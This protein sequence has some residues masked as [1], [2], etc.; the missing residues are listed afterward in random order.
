MPEDVL[1]S[2]VSYSAARS[3][4]QGWL[5]ENPE[6][7]LSDLPMD[8]LQ[9]NP[10]DVI[11]PATMSQSPSAPGYSQNKPTAE[12]KNT[13]PGIGQVRDVMTGQNPQALQEA[14]NS[15]N[16]YAQQG[17]N[18]LGADVTMSA[19]Q[20]A[21]G[22]LRIH[23][24]LNT[25][26]D[27]R[28]TASRPVSSGAPV[29]SLWD[30]ASIWDAV[31]KGVNK[32]LDEEQEGD[33]GVTTWLKA[34]GYAVYENSAAVGIGREIGR[35]AEDIASDTE[36]GGWFGALTSTAANLGGFAYD[37]AHSAT[38]GSVEA[39]GKLL[40]QAAESMTRPYDL[41]EKEILAS[42]MEYRAIQQR[43][44]ARNE[45]EA[46]AIDKTAT[47]GVR[48]VWQIPAVQQQEDKTAEASADHDPWAGPSQ[49]GFISPDEREARRV[50]QQ[51]ERQLRNRQSQASRQ[52]AS[53]QQNQSA[54]REAE[55][56]A[57]QQGMQSLAS[58]MAVAA[59][60]M[61]AY[62]RAMEQQR[63][64]QNQNMQRVVDGINQQYEDRANSQAQSNSANT[65]YPTTDPIAQ[66]YGQQA[67]TEQ[68]NPSSDPWGDNSNQYGQQSGKG[69]GAGSTESQD[70]TAR[71][72]SGETGNNQCHWWSLGTDLARQGTLDAF[73]W[74]F[75]EGCDYTDKMASAVQET[76]S[77][78]A[79]Y[80]L[81]VCGMDFIIVN[82]KSGRSWQ[83]YVQRAREMGARRIEVGE[84]SRG[85]L[86][87]CSI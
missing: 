11:D 70:V 25:D 86:I 48:D 19:S 3:Q 28:V 49:S 26:I 53:R 22:A 50:R 40:G 63:Q 67:S 87:S 17:V 56:E 84:G 68:K 76:F 75:P 55:R 24:R 47:E 32:A 64:A 54:Q 7:G 73:A 12:E 41:H 82:K 30:V 18:R 31:S 46:E 45:N 57:F 13:T 23:S 51:Q 5:R 34:T 20:D 36:E 8:D 16:W 60:E 79:A 27:S 61:Q 2:I 14:A 43:M 74:V 33:S 66:R 83:S 52:V 85:E 77:G 69:P 10:E 78:D 1:S 59:Q 58:G 21:D 29:P 44:Q 37:L 71:M 4:V 62:D 38:V 39:T 6:A 72:A 9:I 35:R 65:G 81:S 42:Q 80:D 15:V